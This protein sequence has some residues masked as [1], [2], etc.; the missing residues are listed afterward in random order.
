MPLDESCTE[1]SHSKE[2]AD[3]FLPTSL[4]SQ[5][6]LSKPFTPAFLTLNILKEYN[7]ISPFTLTL[8]PPLECGS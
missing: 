6:L 7:Q 2:I 4:L 1:Q 8:L 5:M 3:A